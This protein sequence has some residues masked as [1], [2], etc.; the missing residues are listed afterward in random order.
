MKESWTFNTLSL[1]YFSV[2]KTSENTAKENG[3]YLL[4]VTLKTFLY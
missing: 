3:A 4:T 2:S 1:E